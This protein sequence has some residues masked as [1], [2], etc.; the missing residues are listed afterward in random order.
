[1][2]ERPPSLWKAVFRRE[3][4]LLD[5]IAA[6]RAAGVEPV[7]A[8]TPYPVHALDGALGR[9]PSRLPWVS[10]GAGLGGALSA[11]LFQFYAAVWDWP[12][13]V[14]GKPANSTLAFLPITFEATVLASGVLTAVA[15]LALCRL[16]PGAK[17]RLPHPRVTDDRFALLVRPTEAGATAGPSTRRLLEGTGACQVEEVERPEIETT[18]IESPEEIPEEM[19]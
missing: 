14:G 5:A 2:T 15:F 8:Y 18:E 16:Y 9:R 6:C 4:E 7:E 19:P 3:A 1:M 12:I 17:P 11:L 13:N 10:L